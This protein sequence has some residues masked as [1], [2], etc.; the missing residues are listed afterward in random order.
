MTKD[1]MIKLSAGVLCIGILVAAL[2]LY[3]GATGTAVLA[4]AATGASLFAFVASYELGQNRMRTSA[5]NQ[6]HAFSKALT[7]VEITLPMEK[8]FR[9]DFP[10]QGVTVLGTIAGG[11]VTIEAVDNLSRSDVVWLLK[12]E[13]WLMMPGDNRAHNV[14]LQRRSAYNLIAQQQYH[15]P[16]TMKLTGFKP[17]IQK[18]VAEAA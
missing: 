12:S 16:G 3:K 10:D 14:T 6:S 9:Q 1:L 7:G 17:V 13:L 8:T 4:L 18:P 15:G 2:A 11:M 5:A